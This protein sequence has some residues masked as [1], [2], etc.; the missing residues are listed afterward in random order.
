MPPVSPNVG[1]ANKEWRA[2]RDA[3]TDAIQTDTCS[4]VPN[5][6]AQGGE[7]RDW[8]VS[9]DAENGVGD[10]RVMEG[11]AGQTEALLIL[12]QL[13]LANADLVSWRLTLG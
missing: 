11:G 10:W 6:S 13:A 8:M 12:L 3:K 9:V 5:L 7:R 4:P 1:H 2:Q